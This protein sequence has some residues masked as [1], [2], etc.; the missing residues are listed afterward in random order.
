MSKTD[1]DYSFRPDPCYHALLIYKN[2]I[3]I[4][5]N[6][7]I[8]VLSLQATNCPASSHVTSPLHI[9]LSSLSA[10]S[11]FAPDR[12]RWACGADVAA[13]GLYVHAYTPSTH[14]ISFDVLVRLLLDALVRTHT[15]ALGAFVAHS[16]ECVNGA[17]V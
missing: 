7:S 8:P 1:V 3:Y 11:S 16:T 12:S 17:A 14:D 4:D 10:L 5:H 13:S 15:D 9:S 2:P 6:P